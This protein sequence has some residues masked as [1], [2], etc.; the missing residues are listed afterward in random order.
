MSKNIQSF[1]AE[2]ADV[3][4]PGGPGGHAPASAYT[5]AV[6]LSTNDGVVRV[7]GAFPSV[8]RYPDTMDVTP[9]KPGTLVTAFQFRD[10][11]VLGSRELP[12]FR[13]CTGGGTS[14]LIQQVMALSPSEKAA[15]RAAL[16]VTT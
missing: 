7:V 1:P 3:I 16:G 13:P 8:E 15:L 2:V 14:N 12:Y 11:V 10:T 5:Y 6:D 9:I 4:G